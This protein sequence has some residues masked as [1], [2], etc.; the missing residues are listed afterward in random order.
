[1]SRTESFFGFTDSNERLLRLAKIM[2]ALVPLLVGIFGL[3]STYHIIFIAEALGGGPGRY[4]QGLTLLSALLVVQLIVQTA[5]D[6]PTGSL[7]DHI[8]QRWVISSAYIC[9][10]ISF[11]LTSIIT[12][13]SPFIIFILIFALYA[14]GGSQESGAWA[15]WFDN[16][17]R[18]AMPGD[19]DRKQYGVFQGRLGMLVTISSIIAIVPGSILA[20]FFGRPWV[21][22]IV[23]VVCFFIAILVVYLVQDFEEV[24]ESREARPSFKAY[25]GILKSGVTFL[26]SQD[27]VKWLIIGDMLLLSTMIVWSNFII[28]PLFFAYLLTDVAVAS[29]RTILRIPGVFTEERSGIW[30]QRF[31]PRKWIPR[32]RLIQ[33]CGFLF[34]L[35]FAGLVFLF[36]PLT[37]GTIVQFYFPNTD[38]ILLAAP[39]ESLIPVAIML[40]IFVISGLLYAFASILT[41]RVILDQIPNEIRNSIYS[42]IPTVAMLFAIP[43]ILIVGPTIQSVGFIPALL[44]IALVSLVGTYMIHKALSY[45]TPILDEKPHDSES[46]SLVEENAFEDEVGLEIVDE[47]ELEPM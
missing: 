42:L 43:Q 5:L 2:M 22:Q 25:V 15:A 1:M 26:A 21:F 29:F 28:F 30:S 39:L 11:F 12:P 9:Y 14:I 3:V 19:E 18:V 6:Y 31:E 27:L 33:T 20:A 10:G 32:F 41:Q 35:L 24:K 36:P 17:F 37:G 7:G 40:V 38:I 8:G 46:Q 45:P 23:A 13:E 47:T 44:F 16:N 34:Y 4:I